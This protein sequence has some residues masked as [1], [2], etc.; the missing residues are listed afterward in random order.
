MQTHIPYTLT[1]IACAKP[2]GLIPVQCDEPTPPSIAYCD[3]LSFPMPP[4]PASR[5]SYLSLP[6][7][8]ISLQCSHA[9]RF[10]IPMKAP[11]GHTHNND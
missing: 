9:Y 8:H 11:L 7:L 6:I 2:L 1:Q 3:Y 4:L 10:P 5:A